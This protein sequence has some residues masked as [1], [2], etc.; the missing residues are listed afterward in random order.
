MPR[1]ILVVDDT[2]NVQLML[3]DFLTSQDFAVL[4]ASDGRE[5]LERTRQE[6][7]DLILL[8]IMMP[9]MDGYQFIS[10][11]RRESALPVIMITAKQQEADLVRGFELGADDYITKPFR[12]RELLMRMRAVLRRAAPPPAQ[13]QTLRVG[14]LLLD[15][16]RHEVRQAEQTVELTPLE[17]QILEILMQAPGEVI[18]RADLAMRLMENG[19]TGSEATLKIHIRNL[20]L[21][22]DDDLTQPRYIETV[23]G[24]GYRLLET[25]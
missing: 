18:R 11:L 4:T 9:N 19:Y 16:S 12:M 23:F 15:R 7:P 2:R 14:N 22:L 10:Q 5:A 1:K 8:D 25:P 17:F 6:R 24:V 3:E 20:R 21:K 13:E